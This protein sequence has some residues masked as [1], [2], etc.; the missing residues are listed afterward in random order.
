MITMQRCNVLNRA[1]SGLG[2]KVNGRSARVLP[3]CH[4]TQPAMVQTVSNLADI[5][6]APFAII[7]HVYDQSLNMFK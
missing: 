2:N 1:M 7:R 6:R 5:F 3:S 4:Y